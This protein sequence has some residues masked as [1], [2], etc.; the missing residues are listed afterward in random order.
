MKWSW[1]I[2]RL[3]GINVYMH[4]TFL[5]LI[6]FVLF[7][8]YSDHLSAAASVADIV[9]VLIIFVCIVLH[10]L[11]HAL[12]ARRFG[13]QTRDIV[14]LPIGGVAR[15]ERMPEKPSEELL[16]AIAGPLVNVVIAGALLAALLAAGARP[17]WSDFLTISGGWIEQLMVVNVWLLGFNLLPAFPMDG[18]RIL[19]AILATRLDYTRATKVA[20]RVGQGMAVVFALA[21]IPTSDVWLLFIALF[22]WM[23]AGAEASA[24]AS[25]ASL[26]GVPV[27]QVMLT[28]F[29]TVGPDDTL[30]HASSGALGGWQ[31]D[32]PVV[33]GDRVLGV[34]TREGLSRGL[35]EHGPEARVRDAMKRDFPVADPQDLLE[36]ALAL[37]RACRCRSIPV[38]HDGRLV[39]I[40]SADHIARYLTLTSAVRAKNRNGHSGNSSSLP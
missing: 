29:R 25:H 18:G 10:E 38:E 3:A 16:V 30:E 5:L 15:L 22:V 23:G 27:R 11:G 34:L 28:E 17:Q 20:A 12:M 9:L 13:V 35:S 8:N 21:A 19:R 33:F 24:T 6:L 26:N 31:Q 4:A 1:K 36:H 39:G 2:G 7:V 14:L 32:F 37:L 40:L